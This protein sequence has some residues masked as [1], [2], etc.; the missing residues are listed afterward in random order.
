[1]PVSSITP[2]DTGIT[3]EQEAK[4]LLNAA[5][6]SLL[7]SAVTSLQ[8]KISLVDVELAGKEDSNA[9]NGLE[10][11]YSGA[12]INAASDA[13]INAQFPPAEH[14]LGEELYVNNVGGIPGKT[15]VLKRL[16]DVSGVATWENV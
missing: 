6:S 12:S 15:R 10:F 2:F 4:I 11:D 13:L 5:S 9:G 3:A 7:A 14:P 1:M 16:T 8:Q